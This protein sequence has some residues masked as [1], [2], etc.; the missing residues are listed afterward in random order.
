MKQTAHRTFTPN[1]ART[2]TCSP[3]CRSGIRCLTLFALTALAG[4]PVF[5]GTPAPVHQATGIKICE[6]DTTSAIIWT[7]LTKDPEHVSVNGSL[8]TITYPAEK[9]GK[10]KK[11]RPD[12]KPVVTFPAGATVDT[13]Q[14]AAPGAPGQTRVLYRARGQADWQNTPW[15]DEDARRDFTR[16]YRLAN[17]AA[18][19]AP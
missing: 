6:V 7:R 19:T 3:R 10:K 13:L 8:L 16:Q 15:Q 11:N 14:G 2:T 17:L 9:G 1:S 4:A 12:N 5:A 18:A